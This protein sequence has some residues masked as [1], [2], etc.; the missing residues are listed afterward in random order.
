VKQCFF[1]DIGQQAAQESDHWQMGSK[2][3][4]F[5]V[6]IALPGESFQ[7][8]EQRG[9]IQAEPGNP[10]KL[11]RWNWNIKEDQE[12]SSSMVSVS[13]RRELCWERIPEKDPYAPWPPAKDWLAHMCEQR[14]WD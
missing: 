7:A 14:T 8:E 4:I 10:P 6:L 1:S 2:Q 9:G 12:S 13:E 3:M 5:K 11:R